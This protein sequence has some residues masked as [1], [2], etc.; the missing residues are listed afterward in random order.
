MRGILQM[1]SYAVDVGFHSPRCFPIIAAIVSKLISVLNTKEE[2]LDA[3]NRVRRKLGQLPNNGHLEVWQQRV[4][5]H[6]DKS[7]K[8]GEKLCCLVSE[9]TVELW[10][11]AWV[12]TAAIK[13]AAN[14]KVIVNQSRLKAMRLVVPRAEFALFIK[15][16]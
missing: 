1:I 14:P 15:P 13:N 10:S 16:Y 7:V 11:N 12:T 2:K 9:E 6:I 8:Y 4:S 3:L 5:I